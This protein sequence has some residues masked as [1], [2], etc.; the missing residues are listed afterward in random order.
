MYINPLPYGPDGIA[1]YYRLR[2]RWEVMSASFVPRGEM[3]WS[4]VGKKGPS[5][6]GDGDLVKSPVDMRNKT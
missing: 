3:I 1:K 5:T 4:L 2:R 6:A